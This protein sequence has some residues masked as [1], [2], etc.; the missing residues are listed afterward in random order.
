MNEDGLDT[1][2]GLVKGYFDGR[3]N[4]AETLRLVTPPQKL[5]V[6]V[7]KTEFQP[8]APAVLLNDC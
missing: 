3:V 4:E 5:D 8:L 6:S 7:S 2:N 1:A